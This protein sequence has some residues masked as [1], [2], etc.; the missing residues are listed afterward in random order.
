MSEATNTAS[1]M[2][3]GATFINGATKSAAGLVIENAIKSGEVVTGIKVLSATAAVGGLALGI[4]ADL[5]INDESVPQAIVSQVGAAI[6]GGTAIAI[7][8]LLSGGNI[9]LGVAAGSAAAYY[10][11]NAIDG[12]FESPDAVDGAGSLGTLYP[13][14]ETAAAAIGRAAGAGSDGATLAPP[15]PRRDPLVLDLDGDGLEFTSLADSQAMFDLTGDQFATRTAWLKGDD[16]FLVLDKNADGFIN[17]INELFGSATEGGF[18]EL[19]AF[20]SNADG[21]IDAGDTVF[22]DLKV[23]QDFNGDGVSQA[24]ELHSLTDL[25]IQSISLAST[26]LANPV[27]D[28]HLVSEGSFT[29]TDGTTG[30]VGEVLFAT[31]PTLSSFVG[32][33]EICEDIATL[34]DIKGYGHMT[35]LHIAMALDPALQETVAQAVANLNNQDFIAAFEQVLYQWAG[36]N[37]I[38]L[39]EIDPNAL[40]TAN[41]GAVT[42]ARA[43][44]TLTLEQLGVIQAYS[45]LDVL[46]IG[47]GQWTSGGVTQTSGALYQKAWDSLYRNLL[48]KFAVASGYLDD[49]LPGLGYDPTTDLL[50]V[51][52]DTTASAVSIHGVPLLQ[53]FNATDPN[54]I[55]KGLLT[56]LT[57]QEIDSTTRQSFKEL[58]GSFIGIGFA[59]DFANLYDNPL[60]KMLG[61]ATTGSAATD[62]MNGT[63]G[64]DILISLGANDTLHGNGGNDVVDGGEGD[65]Q[66]YGD[67]GDDTLLGQAG[68]DTLYGGNGNDSLY[69]G[70]GDDKLYGGND[71]DTLDGGVGNDV[72]D[73][74][75]GNDQL[76][77]GEGDDKLYG[78]EGNDLLDG[79]VGNDYLEGGIGN[80]RYLFGIGSGQDTLRDYDSTAGNTD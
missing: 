73:G 65:D 22:A 51:G 11:N 41:N 55:T 35:D 36:V 6:A 3:D 38:T 62:T 9:L 13:D 26:A 37:D 28:A 5:T 60:F 40:L 21:R 64:D 61:I 46:R 70:E 58:F 78:S 57:L 10:T 44:V 69:G 49:M 68:M 33:V 66:I 43:G 29:R 1:L 34:P 17:D 63:T 16:G 47:D 18:S 50:S 2:V 14:P 72:L 54:T 79:G 59:G 74:N 76:F 25:N 67:D 20:D 7:V 48:V 39:T 31:D 77:G 15:P 19:S 24:E 56:E 80:D 30:Q 27:T 4:V 8:S 53:L 52:L 71:Q 42:F 45:G 23:W 32:Q 75:S 12:Y